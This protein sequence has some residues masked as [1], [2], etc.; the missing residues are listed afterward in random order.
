MSRTHVLRVERIFRLD[1]T[2]KVIDSYDL[3][4][5]KNSIVF[6]PKILIFSYF[7]FLFSIISID[8]I[9]YCFVFDVL[10]GGGGEG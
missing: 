8:F 3:V 10:R 6:A 2:K 9:F 4:T 7:F 5:R 1:V